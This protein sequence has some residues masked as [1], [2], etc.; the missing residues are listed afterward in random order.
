MWYRADVARLLQVLGA[1]MGCLGV[2]A[3]GCFTDP[4][5]ERPTVSIDPLPSPPVRDAVLSFHATAHDDQS[6]P[7]Q[8]AWGAA[9]TASPC[10]AGDPLPGTPSQFGTDPTFPWSFTTAGW[11]CVFVTVTDKFTASSSAVMPVRIDDQKP[12]AMILEVMAGTGALVAPRANVPLYSNLRYTASA[13]SDPDSTAPLTVRWSLMRPSGSMANPQDPC[14]TGTSD[15]CLPQV[16]DPGQYMLTL[17][18]TDGDGL[19]DPAS[20]PFTVEL[21][22]PPCIQATEPGWD[23]QRVL[24]P[25]SPLN[26]FNVTSV[27]DD[28]DP[29][30]APDGLM[31]MGSFTWSWRKA[32]MGS[33]TGSFTFQALNPGPSFSIPAGMFQL[34]DTVQVR[35]EAND[36]VNRTDPMQCTRDTLVCDDVSAL[37]GPCHRWVTWTV[38]FGR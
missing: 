27:I 24:D 32:V 28:G 7:L 15:I 31:S 30:P 5:N 2:C 26:F 22:Q 33:F 9:D 19:S 35:V 4:V 16:Q 11:H 1:L 36:R 23:V 25:D 14:D 21:D 34:N 18:V 6:E 20:L 13:S 8:F 17:T 3:M 29:L 12:K 10:A 38:E 37:A